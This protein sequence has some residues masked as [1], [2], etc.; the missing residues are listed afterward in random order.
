MTTQ[1][2]EI[3]RIEGMTDAELDAELRRH[4]I[5]PEELVQNMISKLAELCRKQSA[6]LKAA[7]Q[8]NARLEQEVERLKGLTALA[9]ACPVC[10]ADVGCC[11]QTFDSGI[12]HKRRIDA[13]DSERDSLKAENAQLKE[14]IER[15]PGRRKR[16]SDWYAEHYGKLH[17][18][19]RN[20]LPEPYRHQFFSCIANGLYDAIKDVGKPYRAVAGFMVTPG[21]YF[22]M[23]TAQEQILFDQ[24]VRAEDAEAELSALRQR[25]EAMGRPVTDA[26]RKA[27]LEICSTYDVLVPRGVSFANRPPV[28]IAIIIEQALLAARAGEEGA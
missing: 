22:K 25:V 20:V 26:C 14:E 11:C 10:G 6:E 18:W 7:E 2:T 16:T 27:A 24:C 17:D 23:G 19:A 12:V 3:A 8:A 28:T 1:K 13:A 5:D 9:I 15:G 4:G 21:G